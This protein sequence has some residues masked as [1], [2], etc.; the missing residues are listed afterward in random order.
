MLGEEDV[1]VVK[2]DGQLGIDGTDTSSQRFKNN[3]SDIDNDS[4]RLH[5]LR[6]ICFTYKWDANKKKRY[7]LIAEE[8]EKVYPELVLK[9]AEGDAYRVS[10]K[11]L[12]VLMLN[13]MQKNHNDIAEL[14][15]AIKVL[16]V[17]NNHQNVAELQDVIKALV[18]RI[19]ALEKTFK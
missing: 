3:I 4:S 10:Y 17:Q 8:V 13:E 2:S 14:Q 5:Q 7:G 1:V 12:P 9:D 6:P 15:D 18:A 16:V 19:A 11:Q